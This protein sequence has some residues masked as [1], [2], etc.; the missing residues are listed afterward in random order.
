MNRMRRYIVLGL[1]AILLVLPL[2]S[3]GKKSEKAVGTCGEY[4]I[5][6]EEVRYEVLTYR[7]KHPDC[8]EEELRT[9]V[10]QAIRE[11]Y[12][13]AVLCAQYTPASSMDS[14]ALAERAKADIENLIASLGG[15]SE[16]KQYLK[17]MYATE[18]L[19]E[20]LMV[21][22]L[23]QQDLENTVFRQ[24]EL[25]HAEALLNWW[26]EGNCVQATKLIFSDRQAAE[27]ARVLA[28]GTVSLESL[29]KQNEFATAAVEPSTYYFRNLRGT[30]EEALALTLEDVGDAT[31]VSES[32]GYAYFFVCEK[33]ND[34]DVLVYQAPSALSI[35]RE[36]RISELIISAAS[37]LTVTWNEL[38]AEL[39]LSDIE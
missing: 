14:E 26:R 32:D 11:R 22:A 38:G 9:A 23:M 35:Y 34:Y 17:E 7:H 37:E 10:E 16:Y 28:D 31:A 15:K 13:V 19:F 18:H 24:T 25:E 6:Y 30:P 12:A 21:L 39:V 2:A 3:C 20:R 4:E 29:L 5:L 36:N 8:T 33:E 1:V 27:A